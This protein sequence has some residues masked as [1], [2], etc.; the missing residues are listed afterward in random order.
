MK[1]TVTFTILK[2]GKSYDIQM[3]DT[4]KISETLQVLQ[5]NLHLFQDKDAIYNVR[6]KR[7]GRH[8]R[9]ECT[10]E[11]AGIYSGSELVIDA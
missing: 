9:I 1:I 2:T 11:E 6:E 7:S 5:D 8:I 4:Q 3:T 10:Y